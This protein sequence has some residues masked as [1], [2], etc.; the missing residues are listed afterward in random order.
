MPSPDDDSHTSSFLIQM[1]FIYPS[2]ILITVT[3]TSSTIL[4]KYGDSR[5]PWFASDQKK[6][7]FPFCSWSMMLAVSLCYLIFI[8]LRCVP[9]FQTSLRVVIMNRCRVLLNALSASIIITAWFLFF[10][11]LM[12]YHIFMCRYCA[13][14]TCQNKSHFINVCNI[15]N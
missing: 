14:L 15:F 2:F 9:S 11:L 6:I 5:H 10:I 12:L 7:S 13:K 3:R 1:L 8:T 4:N